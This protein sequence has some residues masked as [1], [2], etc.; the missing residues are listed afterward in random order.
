M[1]IVAAVPLNVVCSV[2]RRPAMLASSASCCGCICRRMLKL[3]PK[4]L[5]LF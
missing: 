4:T 3:I 1:T 2:F 5:D